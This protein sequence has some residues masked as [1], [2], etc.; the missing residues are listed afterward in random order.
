MARR[1]QPDIAQQFRYVFKADGRIVDEIFV[2]AALCTNLVIINSSKS[3]GN[4]LFLLSK[5]NETDARPILTA[6]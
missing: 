2:F 4:I 1:A 6:V 5:T 3:I